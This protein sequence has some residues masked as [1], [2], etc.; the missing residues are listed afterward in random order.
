MI[1]Y[2]FMLL[3]NKVIH[4]Y[5]KEKKQDSKF[6]QLFPVFIRVYA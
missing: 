3:I 4:G 2:F 6:W 1:C 5:Y